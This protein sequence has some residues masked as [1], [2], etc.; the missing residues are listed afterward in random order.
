MAKRMRRTAAKRAAT[1][2]T[3]AA[4]SPT[5]T[6]PTDREVI[7]SLVL[8]LVQPVL[9]VFWRHSRTA[10]QSE[11]ARCAI[12]Y[13]LHRSLTTSLQPDYVN[14]WFRW[15]CT[16]SLGLTTPMATKMYAAHVLW[17]RSIH[18]DVEQLIAPNVLTAIAHKS[19]VH[20]GLKPGWTGRPADLAVGRRWVTE[21]MRYVNTVG[22]ASDKYTHGRYLTLASFLRASAWAR[23]E[24]R[25]LAR[26]ATRAKTMTQLGLTDTR[27]PSAATGMQILLIDKTGTMSPA[28]MQQEAAYRCSNR[29]KFEFIELV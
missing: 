16:H 10:I 14:K 12:V 23:Q 27:R 7:Q 26:S 19:V 4:T 20:D 29:E 8:S 28:A 17:S 25:T 5:I 15:A 3:A 6:P 2:R 21:F 13:N 24:H 22:I 11:L 9:E 18:R 1:T